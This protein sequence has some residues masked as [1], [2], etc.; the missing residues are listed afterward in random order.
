MPVP[1]AAAGKI[2]IADDSAIFRG[3]LTRILESLPRFR[4]CGKASS[5]GEAIEKT[6]EL[7]PDLVILDLSMP[8]MNGFETA[9]KI[10]AAFPSMAILLLSVHASTE[11]LEEAYNIGI[12]GYVQKGVGGETLIEALDALLNGDE[13]FLTKIE[14]TKSRKEDLLQ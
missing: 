12:R 5:G 14:T 3:E 4:V 7:N 8:D 6:R 9:R 11:F 1:A 10:L 2:L 13:Y